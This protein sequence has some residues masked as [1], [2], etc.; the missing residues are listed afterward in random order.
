MIMIAC[1]SLSL[2]LSLSLLHFI[3]PE[4]LQQV[5]ETLLIASD[6]S[7]DTL[8]QCA[9]LTIRAPTTSNSPSASASSTATARHEDD[10]E[11]SGKSGH[12]SGSDADSDSSS[13]DGNSNNVNDKD[14]NSNTSNNGKIISKAKSKT[15][16]PQDCVNQVTGYNLILTPQYMMLVPRGEK[17]YLNKININSFGELNVSFMW[18]LF[19]YFL[20]S[21]CSMAFID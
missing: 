15:I 11:L 8:S 6:I 3:L 12:S 2:S 4:Y 17:N 14:Y 7:I 18:Y 20:V 1:L 16:D 10:D 21:N 5:Y 19:Y 13:G 9:A